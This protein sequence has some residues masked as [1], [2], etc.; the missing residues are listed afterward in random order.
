MA[1]TTKLKLG[2]LGGPVTFG[3]QATLVM[4]QLYPEFG[5]VLFF[6]RGELVA[7]AL[8]AGRVDATVGPVETARADF[9]SRTVERLGRPSSQLY[10]IAEATHTYHCSLLVKPGSRLEDIRRVSG[11]TGSVTQCRMWLKE[12]LPNAEVVIVDTS[13]MGAAE[14]VAQNDGTFASIGTPE[15]ALHFGLEELYREIDGGSVACYW[16]TSLLPLFIDNPSRVVISARFP[17][18]GQLAHLITSMNG[19]GF[20]LLT[21]YSQ[22]GGETVFEYDYVLRFGGEGTLAGVQKALEGFPSAR[23]VGAFERRDERL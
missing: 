7:D 17:G 6:P 16:A 11:H 12:H 5:E 4:Q 10:V 22:A 15:A 1:I 23:L 2:A 8:R 21:S 18:D 9:M 3:G 14:E 20:E 19:I 13:S